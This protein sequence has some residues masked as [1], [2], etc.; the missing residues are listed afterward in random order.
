MKTK[1]QHM[2]EMPPAS[3][4]GRGG[5][6]STFHAWA[7]RTVMNSKI[8]MLIPARAMTDILIQ[9]TV[10]AKYWVAWLMNSREP[11]IAATTNAVQVHGRTS[12]AS[13]VKGRLVEANPSRRRSTIAIEPI[14]TEIAMTCT[15]SMVVK[16]H[17]V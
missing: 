9:N 14:T 17:F 8:S 6:G 10:L 5:V 11:A 13:S 2:I 1:A 12:L 7:S 16:A 15:T 3:R 4:A